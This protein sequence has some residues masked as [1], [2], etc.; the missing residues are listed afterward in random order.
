MPTP[1]GRCARSAKR[2]LE[3]EVA[4][5]PQRSVDLPATAAPRPLSPRIVRRPKRRADS[6]WRKLGIGLAA[7]VALRYLVPRLLRR[8]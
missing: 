5:L 6:P 3:E 2:R 8:R 4:D 7:G 1:S